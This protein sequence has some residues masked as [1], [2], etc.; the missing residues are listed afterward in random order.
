MS[1]RA[2]RRRIERETAIKAFLSREGK[3]NI[4]MDVP[5][6][7]SQ[8]DIKLPESVTAE[9]GERQEVVESQFKIYQSILPGLL[10]RLGRIEDIRTPKKIKHQ[11]TIILLYGI[12]M[13]V[14][15]MTS[16]REAN[17]EMNSA[18]FF[19]NIKMVFP[20]IK[21]LPHADTLERLLENIEVDKIEDALTDLVR[22]MI[23]NKKFKNFLYEKGYAIAIDGTQKHVRDYRVAEEWLK[24]KVNAK[25]GE[26]KDQYYVYVLEAVLVFK[27]GLRFP[28]M[29]E[30]LDYEEYK[31]AEGKQDSET[32]AFKRLTER[33]KRAFP[34]LPITLLLDGLYPNGP[35]FEICKKYNW[36]F[37]I[38]LQD[39]NLK[40]VWQE[41]NNL[42]KYEDD[43]K[44]KKAEIRRIHKMNWADREQTFWWV[45]HL[46]HEYIIDGI[47]KRS[48]IHVVVCEESWEVYSAKEKKIQKK[49]SRHAWVSSELI[50]KENVHERCNLMGRSRWK[51]ETNILIEKK[52]GYGYEH[53]F[54]YNWNAMRGFHYL[55]HIGHFLN[56]IMFN[57]VELVEKVKKYGVTGFIKLLRKAFCGYLLD[58][59]KFKYMLTQKYQLRLN[60]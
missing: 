45:N 57:T 58:E 1:K 38:V 11:H 25:E 9:L 44:Y 40:N 14:F 32:K 2:E 41:V 15:N 10:K 43:D 3:D 16:R 7:A 34:K 13:F 55:M 26:K 56:E 48:K 19:E 60:W 6:T 49:N 33:I 21:E 27:N 51:I 29:S 46:E 47:K 5:R 23:R 39:G 50:D 35:V 4:G 53:C 18:I 54:S 22:K 42:K 17:S 30:F 36:G 12:L 8:S 37:M 52:Y 28:F 20:E 31:T 24:R 59:E